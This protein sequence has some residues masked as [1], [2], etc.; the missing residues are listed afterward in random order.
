M[1]RLS[2]QTLPDQLIEEL[3]RKYPAAPPNS[4]AAVVQGVH[5]RFDGRPQMVRPTNAGRP[6]G[7]IAL[8]EF[9]F[10][11]GRGRGKV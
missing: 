11:G 3:M 10:G 4:V 1:I 2:E 7:T 5:A 9:G 8:N 6:V